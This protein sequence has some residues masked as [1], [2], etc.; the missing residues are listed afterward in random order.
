MIKAVSL[1]MRGLWTV[2]YV[3]WN[4]KQYDTT[5]WYSLLPMLYLHDVTW[6]D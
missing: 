5:F 6:G 1:E 2:G 4:A 3:E